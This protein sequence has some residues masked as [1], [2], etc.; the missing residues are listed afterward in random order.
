[1]NLGGHQQRPRP[2]SLS[3]SI[4]QKYPTPQKIMENPAFILQFLNF[5]LAFCYW[6]RNNYCFTDTPMEG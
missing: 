2:V 3:H 5:C 4:R 6:R 1:M